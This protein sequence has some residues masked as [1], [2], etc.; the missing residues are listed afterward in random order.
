VHHAAQAGLSGAVC[1]LAPDAARAAAQ[2]GA[3]RQAAALYALALEHAAPMQPAERAALHVAHSLECQHIQRTD[4]ALVSRSAALALHRQL[5]DRLAEGRDLYELALIQHY[6]EGQGASLPLA[7]DAID[8]LQ[9]LDAPLELGSAY[10]VLG[11]LHL[12]DGSTAVAVKWSEKALA[13]I[14]GVHDAD[15]CRAYALNTLA[16]SQLRLNDSPNAWQQL[17]RSL[18]IA[19]RLGQDSHVAAGYLQTAAFSLMH[20]RYSAALRACEKGMAYCEARDLDIYR[21]PFQIRL[22]H[23]LL[24]TGQWNAADAQVM[25]MQQAVALHA[26][27]AKQLASLQH[28][29]NL[30]CGR[31]ESDPYWGALIHGE[32]AIAVGLWVAPL[33]V[34]CCEAAWLR[35]DD[36]AVQHIAVKALEQAIGD[37]EGW[38]I[39]Q[40]LCWLQRAGGEPPTVLQAMARLP[41]PL[42]L[43]CRLELEGD[44]RAAAQAWADLGCAY[45]QALVLLHGDIG[46]LERALSVLDALGALPA[47]RI[48]RRRLR[49]HGVRQVPRGRNAATRGDPLG[50]TT[51]EREVLELLAQR[52]SNGAIAARLHRSERTVENH[53]A[54]LV[55]KLGASNRQDAVLRAGQALKN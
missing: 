41:L 34:A 43:P 16:K 21:L 20:R 4:D 26:V 52:L 1:Q 53:V 32:G 9:G 15:E 12:T 50:L 8:V 3:H 27:D 22:G 30:R 54:T 24:E 31:V 39:G 7:Q 42:P 19:L 17:E 40:L 35:G 10:A 44:H 2:A 18:A 45:Q 28:L 11:N 13:L 38:R 37:G 5:G 14:E 48:A 29:I 36:A 49:A 51:R 25:L 47:A 46:D 55:A 6:R 23:V 33:P